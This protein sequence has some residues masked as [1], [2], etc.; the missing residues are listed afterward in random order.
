MSWWYVSRFV[1]IEL[2][3]PSS[4]HHLDKFINNETTS[5]YCVR[6]FYCVL[7]LIISVFLSIR[8]SKLNQ[9]LI[10]CIGENKKK[11]IKKASVLTLCLGDQ[12]LHIMD[13]SSNIRLCKMKKM[14][15]LIGTRLYHTLFT[16]CKE[17]IIKQFFLNFR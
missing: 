10:T 2:I 9:F 5:T 8:G 15:F 6:E 3:R 7:L 4:S 17:Y 14:P 12:E 11:K 13:A 1:K 16:K